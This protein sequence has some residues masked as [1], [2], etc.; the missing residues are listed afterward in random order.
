MR[1][2]SRRVRH[3]WEQRQDPRGN[4]YY[5]NTIT[6]MT[7]MQHPVDYHYQ[8]LY[9]QYKMQKT[10]A[11][12]YALMSPRSRQKYND[13]AARAAGAPSGA[14]PMAKLDLR[15]VNADKED[16]E[17]AQAAA[18]EAMGMQAAALMGLGQDM[19]S[20]ADDMERSGSNAASM[21]RSMRF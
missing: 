8:Q 3:R 1:M 16:G 2:H 19:S 13:D 11:E 9:L 6:N 12:Q 10:Q 21:M 5:C 15:S 18:M 14:S 20:A 7:M 17:G 4:T